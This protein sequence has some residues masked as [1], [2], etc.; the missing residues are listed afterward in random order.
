MPELEPIRT[1]AS[2]HP[3]PS[4]APSLRSLSSRSRAQSFRSQSTRPNGNL[5]RIFSGQH[6]D[7]VSV[8]HH[9]YDHE[10][11]ND[12]QHT[13][14]NDSSEETMEKQDDAEARE[15]GMEEVPEV[16]QGVKDSRDLEVG[17]PTLEKKHTSRSIKDPNLVS[18]SGWSNTF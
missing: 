2:V 16:R 9:D 7:D 14:S 17:R 12:D 15:A 13:P 18:F 5:H 6:L 4:R 11:D 10:R 8:Y 1:T 3:R